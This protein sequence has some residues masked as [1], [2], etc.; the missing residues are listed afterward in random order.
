MRGGRFVCVALP[1]ILCLAAIIA[2]LYAVLA[3]VTHRNLY[4]FSVDLSNLTIDA[5][6]A[7]NLVKGLDLNNLDLSKLDGQTED[8]IKQYL[9]AGTTLEDLKNK[10]PDGTTLD[11]LKDKLPDGTDLSNLGGTIDNLLNNNGKARRDLEAR[12]DGVVTA[13]SLG[14]GDKWQVSLWGYCTVNSNGN[15]NCTSP[16]WNWAAKHFNTSLLDTIASQTGLNITLPHELHDALAVFKPV[17]KWTQIGF[18]TSLVAL[19]IEFV[20]GIFATCTRVVSCLVWLWAGITTALVIA[21]ATAATVTASVVVGAIKSVGHEYN[22]KASVNTSFLATIWIGAAFS[23]AAGLFWILTMCCCK[24]ESRQERKARKG[25]NDG[26]KLLPGF[27]RGGYGRLGDDN[28]MHGGLGRSPQPS[29]GFSPAFN[30][31]GPQYPQNARSDL[32]YEPFSTRA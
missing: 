10:L 2:L 18:A 28:E 1:L 7:T 12:E 17:T 29:P 24:P 13:A 25:F 11:D 9:P 22:A 32:A 23:V 5:S 8:L 14:L 4:M 30:H 20:F 21:T 19:A 16:E 6:E 15:R 27:Q 3:G 31:G 26:E